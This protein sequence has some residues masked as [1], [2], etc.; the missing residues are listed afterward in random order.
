MTDRSTTVGACAAAV[1]VVFAAPVAV[2]QGVA[3]ERELAP[4]VVS[5]SVEHASL[6][7]SLPSSTHSTTRERLDTQSFTNT[8]DALLY[9]PNTHVRKRFVGDRNA[10]LSGRSF[11][12]LQ[13]AR[14][15]AYVDGYMISNFLGRFDAPRW[16]IVAPE[17]VARTDVLYGPFSAIYPGNSIGT[18]VAISTREPEAFEASLTAQ[19]HRQKHDDYGLEDNY[20][21]KQQSLWV[22]DRIGRLALSVSANRLSFHS[23][24]MA[25]ATA[26]L[27]STPAG[28]QPVASGARQD[29]DPSGNARTVLG[30]T[31][32][33]Q[34]VQEQGTL[35]AAYELTPALHADVFFARW[36]NDYRVSNRSLL[37]DEDGS[38]LWRPVSGSPSVN[39]DGFVYTLPLM[40]PQEGRDAHEQIGGRL[41]TRNA[42][43]WNHS[44][45]VSRYRMRKD[46]LRQANVSDPFAAGAAGSDTRRDGT[47]W[48][49]FELQ[50]T[51]TPERPDGH[52]L[53]FGFHRNQYELKNRVFDLTDWNHGDSRSGESQNYFGK[54]EV[55]ALYAQDVWRFAPD[56]QLTAGLRL[57]RYR[58]WDGSQYIAAASADPSIAYDSRRDSGASPKLS[59]SHFLDDEWVVKASWGRGVRFPT[60]SEL[61]QGTRSGNTLVRNDPTLKPER[62]DAFELSAQREMTAGSL[63]VSLFQDDV[64][65][66]IFQQPQLLESGNSVVTVQ[67]IDRVR[68]RGIELA[69]GARNLWLAG[70]DVEASLA[71]NRARTLSNAANPQYEGKVFPRIPRVRAALFASY[72]Q[73]AWRSSVGVRHSGRQYNTL[74]NSDQYPDT[75]GGTSNFTV[76]DVK[77]VR[78]LGPQASLAVGIDNLTDRRYYVHHPY[79]G[80]SAYAELKLAY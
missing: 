1:L 4:V 79:P 9:A 38:P 37:R 45:Q 74:D 50:S 6:D 68:T 18:T 54:T 48:I 14:G 34:G 51:W 47:G 8:E 25:Y 46:S 19:F 60:V 2:A 42:T 61:Y 24:P 44:L 57:E 80:R 43:G 65:D 78:Q 31:G 49:T 35:R 11:G 20:D 75:F 40:A 41:R 17:A 12:S 58:A 15:L 72:T 3:T 39:I 52:A 55:Q 28:A 66:A 33:Q 32:I 64:R 63:R 23:Q 5:D 70:L 10:N 22:G 62:S 13:P 36:R 69:W 77:L 71:F 29:R 73:G 26:A 27:S 53:T 30:A 7:P 56:W 21:N 16:N 59:L 67:N 76:V